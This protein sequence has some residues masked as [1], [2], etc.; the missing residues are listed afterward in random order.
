[1]VRASSLSE[2][3]AFSLKELRNVERKGL[4]EEE[5]L[6]EIGDRELKRFLRAMSDFRKFILRGNVVDLAVG[7]VIGT[8]FTGVVNSFVKDFI[9][10]L[11]GL[12]GV[13]HFAEYTFGPATNPFHLG[14]FLNGV[15]SFIIMAF[16]VFFLVVRPIN[17]LRDR[18]TPTKAPTKPTTRDCPFCLSAIPLKATRCAYCTCEV[19]PVEDVS[20]T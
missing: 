6:R 10:P 11:I 16:V 7:I 3:G 4:L 14:D 18:M 9:T 17:T 12:A 19:A 5:H 13:P 1:M 2:K 8:A 15:I 20:A